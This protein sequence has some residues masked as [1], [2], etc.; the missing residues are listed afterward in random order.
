MKNFQN[1]TKH[2]TKL[3]PDWTLTL[4]KKIDCFIST[5]STISNLKYCNVLL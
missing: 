5:L 4:F 3:L 1:K 2:L